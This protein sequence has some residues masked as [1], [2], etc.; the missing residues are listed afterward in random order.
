MSVSFKKLNPWK[1]ANAN[2]IYGEI[3]LAGNPNVGKSTVFNALTGM[4]QHTGNWSGKTVA[5]AVGDFIYNGKKYRITDIPGTYS[6]L[7]NS[8]EE[9]IA[10]DY[11]CFDNPD[12]V[13][14][15]CDAVCLERNLNLVLQIL[16]ITQNA[17]LCVNMIDETKKKGIKIDVDKL[18]DLLGV[19]VCPVSA[20]RKKGLDNLI[21]KAA[22]VCELKS[23]KHITVTYTP[24]IEELIKTVEEPLKKE[25]FA[26]IN[27]RWLALRLIENDSSIIT[28]VYKRYKIDLKNNTDVQSALKKASERIE[29][30]GYTSE[31]IKDNIASC[32]VMNAEYIASRT[33]SFIKKDYNRSDR[34]IDK[35]I[36][37]K[38]TGIPIMLLMLGIILW[39]TLVGAN[40]PSGVLYDFLMGLEKPLFDFFV[41]AGFAV[42]ISEMLV[43]GVYRVTA[44]VVSVMLPPMA[45]FFPLFTVLEDLG[46]LP[47]VAFNLDKAFKKCRSCGKQALTMCMGFGCNAVGVTGARI[48]DSPRERLI[49]I[50][51]NAFVP[52]NGRFPTLIAI[53]CM[54]F[55]VSMSP[56][57]S[58]VSTVIVL[59]LILLGILMTMLTSF[60]LSK[61]LLKGEPSS[62]ALELPPYRMPDILQVAV[63]SVLNRTVFV[64]GRAVMAA[65]PA[66]LIIWLLANNS[67]GNV[68][69]LNIIADFLDPFASLM[70]LDGVILLAFIL[71]FPANEIV[72]PIVIMAYMSG[73]VL[74]DYSSISQLK[75][76]LI[77]NG[78]TFITALNTMLFVLFHWPCAT[79][80]FTIKKET[81][82]I[83]WTLL[84]A[85]I[86]T[87]IGVLLCMAT[88]FVYNLI[89]III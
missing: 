61:S 50:L 51:T 11:I 32:M 23:K 9:V 75:Q 53:A 2:E 22:A 26:G 82:S 5:N 78:W 42:K 52:C 63:R 68:P 24:F 60:I 64:L 33:V 40:Y 69:I 55:V 62:F 38:F 25:K 17:V 31:V 19:P 58:V 88:N 44:W 89:N 21:E 80:C 65:A 48:I 28:T 49:A 41:K 14:I 1:K 35:Y 18:S 79:T 3:G 10:R 85:V 29:E 46:Y 4:H 84:A 15:V 76:L 72:I 36:T 87:V 12:C 6:L 8:E 70:G 59:M 57:N 81:G 30:E 73:G 77:D 37:G 20:R 67:I 27:R 16:E 54:F 71:G 66:G 56:F 34:K 39:I 74:T 47:R 13:I 45:I 7:A 43:S 83:K 86:P